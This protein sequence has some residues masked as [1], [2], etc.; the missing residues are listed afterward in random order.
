MTEVGKY[1]FLAFRVIVAV[2]GRWPKGGIVIRQFYLIGNKSLPIVLGTGA[3]AGLV[4][5][6]ETY[7]MLAK[8]NFE[9]M[10]G[11]IIAVSILREL[12]PVLVALMFPFIDNVMIR[13]ILVFQFFILAYLAGQ[14]V[15][16]PGPARTADLWLRHDGWVR[17]HRDGERKF[18]GRRQP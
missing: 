14:P 2:F 7:H 13:P 11:A 12:G 5:A 17:V 15:G 6:V 16:N 10:I 3:F 4:L 9:T 8:V 18:C 1:A